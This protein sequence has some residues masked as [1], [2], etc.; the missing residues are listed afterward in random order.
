MPEVEITSPQVLPEEIRLKMF[1]NYPDDTQIVRFFDT[2]GRAVTVWQTVETS[3]YEVYEKA[4]RP[5]LPGAAA[6][7][8]HAMQAFN[9]KLTVTDAAVRFCA[10]GNETLLREWADI[11]DDA[12]KKATRRNQF[13]H[14]STYIMWDETNPNDRIR[15]EPQLYDTRFPAD[16][17]HLR[18]T[19][20]AEITDKFVE[21]SRR[22]SLFAKK[23]SEQL[24]QPQ[25]SA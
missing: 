16:A 9:V 22:L 17:P 7:G 11:K 14:F 3:L 10:A 21:V 6:A 20:I 24:A 4:V 2:L 23:I 1:P 12:G 13:V 18:M 25:A 8:F 5:Q 19:E 15:L